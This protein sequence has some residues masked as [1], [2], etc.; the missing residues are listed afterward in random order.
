[1]IQHYKDYKLV[2][3]C[4]KLVNNTYSVSIIIEKNINN[5]IFSEV[6]MDT[7]ISLIL[8]VEAEN[9][10]INFGKNIINRNLIEF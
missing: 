9:E 2:T 10:S 4:K 7:K 5:R 1:M 3:N 6:F 8:K